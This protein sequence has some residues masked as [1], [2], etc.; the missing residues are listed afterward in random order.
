MDYEI[1]ISLLLPEFDMCTRRNIQG[2]RGVKIAWVS[3]T[4]SKIVII[5]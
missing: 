4:T 5:I 1:A 2:Q 3:L